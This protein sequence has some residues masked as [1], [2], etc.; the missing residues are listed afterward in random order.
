GKR[1]RRRGMRIFRGHKAPFRGV[2]YLPD[3][4]GLVSASRDGAV[5][6]WDLATGRVEDCLPGRTGSRRPRSPVTVP[7]RLPGG[8]P[9]RD[10]ETPGHAVGRGDGATDGRGDWC[11]SGR[12]AFRRALRGPRVILRQRA[13]PLPYLPSFIHL[14][15]K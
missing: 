10:G 13:L 6:V 8:R 3:G 5:K 1:G 12:Q 15:A 14:T 7:G 9:D 4:R 2:S 11:P